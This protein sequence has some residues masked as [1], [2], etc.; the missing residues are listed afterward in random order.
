LDS[1][2]FNTSNIPLLPLSI[3]EIVKKRSLEITSTWNLSQ[4]K[5]QKNPKNF[6]ACAEQKSFPN[7]N[8]FEKKNNNYL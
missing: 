2:L 1:I 5:T 3:Y 8:L 4:K 6:C 7:K